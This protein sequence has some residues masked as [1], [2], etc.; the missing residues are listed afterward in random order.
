MLVPLSA[1]GRSV[2]V[3]ATGVATQDSLRE[4]ERERERVRERGGRICVGV[5]GVKNVGNREE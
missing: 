1:A 4:R 2:S 5:V 3:R